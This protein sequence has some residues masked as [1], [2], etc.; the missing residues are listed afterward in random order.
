MSQGNMQVAKATCRG[1]ATCNLKKDLEGGVANDANGSG[2]PQ[3]MIQNIDDPNMAQNAAQD[4]LPIYEDP[5][6][7]RPAHRSRKLHHA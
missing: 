6:C 4:V 3:D 2:M 1:K 5:P 7:I